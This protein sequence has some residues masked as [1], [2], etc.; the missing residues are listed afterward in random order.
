MSVS[1]QFLGEFEARP[2]TLQVPAGWQING[3]ILGAG[4]MPLEVLVVSA[5]SKPSVSEL[6][7]LW[8]VRL[9]GR[10]TSLLLVVLHDGRAALCGPGGDQPPAFADLDTARIEQLCRAALLEPDRHRALR[11]LLG[12][13][14]EVDAPTP[15]LRNEGLFATHEL[16]SGVPARADWSGARAKAA[17]AK[18]KRGEELLRSLGYSVE[19][20]PGPTSILRAGEKRV[21]VAVLLDRGESLEISSQRFS[22]VSPVSYALAKADAESVRY[23]IALAGPVL[24]LYPVE[25]G[26]GTGRRG[27]TETFV[28][29]HL[30]LLTPEQSSY[31]WLIFSAE[32]LLNGGA[33]DQLLQ[34]SQDYAASLGARLRER[35]Y[36]DVVPPL[37]AA[38]LESR[39]VRNPTAERL[40]ETYQMA[41][42]MLFQLLFVAYAEDKELLPYRTNSLYRARSLKQK[43]KDLVSIARGG[44]AFDESSTHWEDVVRLFRAVDGGSKEWGVP[45]YNGGLFSSDG[46]V[47]PIGAA[48]A[49]ISLDNRTFGPILSRLLVDETPE[50]PGPVDF[51]SLGVRE[52]G[53]I[54]EGLLESEIS[55]A[56]VDLSVVEG[57]KEKGQYRPATGRQRV[58]VKAGHAYLHNAS[59][60]RKSYGSYFT[61]R[62]AV[63][64]LLEHALEPALADHLARLDQLGERPAGAAFFDFRIADIAMGSGHFLVAAVDRIER[65]LSNY[66]VRRPLPDVVGELVRLRTAAKEALG[67]LADGVEI[68][69]TQLLR[70]QVTRRCIF[71][72]DLNPIAV[73]LARVSLWI[74]SFVPGLPLSFLDRNLIVGNALVGIAT[75]E[76]ARTELNSITGTLYG[77][78]ADELVGKARTA[79]ERLGRLS[80]ATAAEIR[81]A[82]KAFDEAKV[83][84]KAAQALFD[85]LTG[86]RLDEGLKVKVFQHATHWVDDPEKAVDSAAHKS[87][88]RLLRAIPPTHMPVAFPEVF[89]R[90]RS[91]FDVIV[92]NPPWEEAT[93][94][95]DRFWNRHQPGLHALS[96][97]E[98]E[99]VKTQLRRARPDLVAQ[100]EEE[101]AQAE[102]LRLVLTA[103]PFPGM[104]TGDPDV[105]KAF[106]WRFWELVAGEG[107]V[108]VVLP[109]TALSA[110]GSTDFRKALLESGRVDEVTTL[111]NTGGWVFDDV[112]PRY[113]IGLVAFQK[114]VPRTDETLPLRGPFPSLSA[115]SAGARREPSRFLVREVLAWTDSAALPLLPTDASA[116]VF[117]QLR[118]SPRL[119]A[120]PRDGWSARP[121][122]ELHATNDKTLMK[123]TDNAPEGYW[124]VYKGESFD[125]WEPDRGVYYA[126]ANP[127]KML[128]A[129]QK[130]RERSARLGLK[131]AFAGF[132]S[133]WIRD[134]DTLPCMFPRI[135][136]RDI[137]RSTD[138]RTMRVALVPPRVFLTNKAPYFIWPR[139]DERDAAFLLGVL[140]SLPLDWYSR[141]FVEL[142]MNYHILNAFPVPRPNRDDR[143]GNRV[144]A[145]AGRLAATL[146]SFKGWAKAVG[147]ACGKLD[148]D[149]KEDMIHELDAVVALLYGLSEHHLRHIF[150]TFHEGWD[151]EARLKPTLKHFEAWRTR[152]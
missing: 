129:L 132:P 11:F 39:R 2:V 135:A 111:L 29:I 84:A 118:R 120:S 89:L 133:T 75:I 5:A 88:C 124:P 136:F 147:V 146:P 93:L 16:T 150:Q 81:E 7:G 102:L 114:K 47:S 10:A 49:Q 21:A 20:M 54:Y 61:K 134:A 130:K 126:W 27:R 22:G 9:A 6:R 144:V 125:I 37:V 121:Y 68:E 115:Y 78:S 139:G 34:S 8:K 106:C 35:I 148:S 99:R 48:L 98:Q 105:Y 97:A 69:D 63:D 32:S 90:Q 66:L 104:A 141:R 83:A 4:A 44:G 127:D 70:R 72:V 74:H 122:A 101:L 94:E 62:F 80:D 24:R 110:K 85:I 112:E 82:R 64:H 96:Q 31:L 14:P 113:T 140:S 46:D 1:A 92:G 77:L 38:L 55:V 91:G 103:G 79:V 13:I 152:G 23:V 138:S 58:A 142:S 87:A 57:G 116:A 123:L 12:A 30:D 137:S 43:A 109:R 50:G 51:R 95:E 119:D 59:G 33:V 151:N 15:G 145:L 73:E 18:S 67:T 107:R 128:K 108:G 52:F 28:E 53:T 25:T 36:D 40:A 76:E 26:V 86:A 149:E 45:A 17:T 3:L 100:Y 41:L 71:G 131:S 60:V 117:A 56:D 19:A 65:A 42:T 143:L